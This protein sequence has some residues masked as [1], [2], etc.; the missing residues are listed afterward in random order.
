[1]KPLNSLIPLFL[2]ILFSGCSSSSDTA[3]T[4]MTQQQLLANSAAGKPQFILDVRTAEE[5]AEGHIPQATNI[6]LDEV[7]AK[8]ADITKLSKDQS[9]PVVV[10]CRSGRRAGLALDILQSNGFTNIYHLEGDMNGWEKA[11]KPVEK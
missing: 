4:I 2:L 7:A 5:F 3:H 10:Y 11:G 1:M 8:L 9:V 6:A